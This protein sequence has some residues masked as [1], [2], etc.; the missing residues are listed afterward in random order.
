MD[1]IFSDMQGYAGSQDWRTFYAV[2]Y[3]TKHFYTQE[4]IEAHATMA[5]S[6]VNWRIIS[7][8]GAGERDKKT[9]PTV[10]TKEDLSG[11]SKK[12][13]SEPSNAKSKVTST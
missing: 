8:Y 13:E 11:P 5:E 1:G 6:R 10:D 2:I 9:S 3:M 4:Q 7:V 12:S